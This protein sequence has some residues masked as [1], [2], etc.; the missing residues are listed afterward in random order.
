M[1][2][3]SICLFYCDWLSDRMLPFT[4]SAGPDYRFTFFVFVFTESYVSGIRILLILF[5]LV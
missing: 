1:P 4:D 2:L 3:L 5:N